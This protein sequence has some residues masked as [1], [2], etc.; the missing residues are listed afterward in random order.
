M[1]DATLI[2]GGGV[3]DNGELPL[4]V[5]RRLDH[6]VHTWQ[7]EPLLCLSAGTILKVVPRD[8]AGFPVFESIAG[9][10][11]L[12]SKGIPATAIFTETSSYDTIG[13]AYFA[14]VIHTEPL[15][16]R[17]LRVITSAFHM[18][19]TRAIFQWVF[20]LH[21]GDTPYTLTFEAVS[22]DGLDPHLLQIRH[23]KEAQGLARLLPL[24]EQIRTL[25]A[26]HHFLFTQHDAYA[27]ARLAQSQ[28]TVSEDVQ[29]LY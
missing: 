23:E 15:G 3:R 5:Q 21:G 7:Q 17:R 24:A 10:R 4:W 18:A 22:D 2:P 29:Q 14:R 27:V 6:A 25:A 13:N 9:A 16:W 1:Y 12:A 8:G 28:P 19:R 20:G 26:L 11:Y